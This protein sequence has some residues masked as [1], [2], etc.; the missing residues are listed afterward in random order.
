MQYSYAVVEILMNHLDASLRSKAEVRTS[1][2]DVLSK[3][4]SI[5]AGE[6]VGNLHNLINV[7]AVSLSTSHLCRL[8]H[9]VSTDLL[10]ASYCSLN[11]FFIKIKIIFLLKF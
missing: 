6:S 3:I 4:I 11:Y 5:A 2:V 1:M 10:N 8:Y 9:S 7:S